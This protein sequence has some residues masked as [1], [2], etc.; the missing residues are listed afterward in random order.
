LTKGKIQITGITDDKTDHNKTLDQNKFTALGAGIGALFGG[1]GAVPGAA[2]GG[3][4]DFALGDATQIVEDGIAGASRGPFTIIDSYGGIGK[5]SEG[6][7]LLASPNVGGGGDNSSAVIAAINQL[8]DAIVNRPITIN[9]DS[10]QV[11]S[12][13]V[14]SSY[15]SA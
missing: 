4:L 5:T 2:I 8:K 15:K 11:G 13:L 7:S 12:A 3:L 1:V 9:L 10:R 6:D 14:Q